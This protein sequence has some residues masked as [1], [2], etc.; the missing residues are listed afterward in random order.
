M[1]VKLF[2][3]VALLL[4]MA[5]CGHQTEKLSEKEQ[6]GAKTRTVLPGGQESARFPPDSV[7]RR[8]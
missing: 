8:Q 1:S 3:A 4:L 7:P 6:G 5:A 2:A